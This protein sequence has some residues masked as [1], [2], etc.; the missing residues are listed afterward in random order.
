MKDKIAEDKNGQ[1]VT[2]NIAKRVFVVCQVH[3]THQV[4][5]NLTE[6]FS[7]IRHCAK[8]ENVNHIIPNKQKTTYPNPLTS[9]KNFKNNKN[10][11]KYFNNC[12]THSINLYLL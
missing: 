10:E 9:R 12:N 4:Y 2:R 8:P 11:K 7:E 3:H 5:N 6:K 1:L